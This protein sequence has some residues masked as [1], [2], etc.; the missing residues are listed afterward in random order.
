MENKQNHLHNENQDDRVL[1]RN[2][3]YENVSF[4]KILRR[5]K[6]IGKEANI[7]I[8][9]T[10]LAMKVIDQLFDGI[11]TTKIDELTAEQCASLSST[12]PDYNTLAGHIVISNHQKNT[13]ESFKHVMTELYQYLDKHD[14]HSPIVTE[15]IYE[16]AN[17]YENEINAKNEDFVLN[18]Q[19]AEYGSDGMDIVAKIKSY[20]SVLSPD[21]RA[22]IWQ[23]I[24]ILKELAKKYKA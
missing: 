11:S 20:W 22:A 5:I 4:D 16:F 8:N 13:S 21:S 6:R 2:G 9:Y 15:Q 18:Y 24:Y 12:H 14:K 23:Y 10:S 19:A 7:H 1:K 17:K 3:E